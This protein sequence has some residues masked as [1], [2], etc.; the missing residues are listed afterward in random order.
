MK[1]LVHGE[2]RRPPTLREAPVCPPHAAVIR[3]GHPVG[4]TALLD[5][6]VPEP[7]AM[8]RPVAAG[9]TLITL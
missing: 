5:E 6:A 4:R 1:A 8:D 3:V 7:A 2:F 9:M